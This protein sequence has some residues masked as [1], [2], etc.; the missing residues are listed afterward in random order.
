MFALLVFAGALF[1]LYYIQD[2]LPDKLLAAHKVREEESQGALVIQEGQSK[3]VNGIF[4]S[5]DFLPDTGKL[6]FTVDGEKV[7]VA[8]LGILAVGDKIY[9]VHG[10]GIG[11]DAWVALLRV[12]ELELGYTTR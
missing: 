4:V 1:T 7:L 2:V 8:D 9:S 6:A 10:W 11:S 3:M 12:G 5:F